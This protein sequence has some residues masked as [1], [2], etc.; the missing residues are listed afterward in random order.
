ME[1]KSFDRINM[2][3]WIWPKNLYMTEMI[4]PTNMNDGIWPKKYDNDEHDWLNMTEI[5]KSKSYH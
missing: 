1:G 4:T 3:K 5:K 2:T